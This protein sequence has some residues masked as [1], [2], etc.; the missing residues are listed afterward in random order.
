MISSNDILKLLRQRHADDFWTS[1]ISC[2]SQ[3]GFERGSGNGRFDFWAMACSWSTP[4]YTGYEIKVNRTD[5]LR[6][7]KWTQYLGA[8][9]R[10]Y[11][12]CPWGMIQP[13]EIDPRTGLMWA[14]KTGNRL[15]TKRKSQPLTPSRSQL[16]NVLK[17]ALMRSREPKLATC[18]VL[19]PEQVLEKMKADE[20][21]QLIG[22]RIAREVLAKASKVDAREKVLLSRE[23]KLSEAVRFMRDIGLRYSEW[24]P[25]TQDQLTEAYR[26]RVQGQIK[27]TELIGSL[28][29]AAEGI[30]VAINLLQE[31]Q[32]ADQSQE[33]P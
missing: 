16:F 9:S 15:V 8:C 29:R 1:E 22:H 18:S 14:T 33:T 32:D 27:E 24:S 5:F 30:S 12:V 17:L 10:F 6:D 26:L 23:E 19:S 28:Q 13:D 31:L 21:D 7:D 2:G 11:W 4:L 20:W 25:P 3:K